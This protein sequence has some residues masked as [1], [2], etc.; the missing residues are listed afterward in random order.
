LN[1]FSTDLGIP[2]CKQALVLA[3]PTSSDPGRY[4]IYWWDGKS[5]D[6][7]LLRELAGIVGKEGE[8]KPEALLPLDESRAGLRVLILFD[9][10]K[11]GAP[12]AVTIPRP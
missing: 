3:G 6:A 1:Q 5:D 12:V 11:K 8:R 7:K 4:A 9:G 10:E 2:D